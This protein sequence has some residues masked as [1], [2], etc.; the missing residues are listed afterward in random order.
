M[1]H[2]PNSLKTEMKQQQCDEHWGGEERRVEKAKPLSPSPL[3]GRQLGVT[4]RHR[5]YFTAEV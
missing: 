3:P 5:N 1:A 2:F 4:E